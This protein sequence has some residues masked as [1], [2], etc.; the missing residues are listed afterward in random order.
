MD[1][2]TVS[3]VL[4]SGGARGLAHIGAIEVL[5]ENGFQISSVAGC[6]MGALIAGVYAKGNLPQF[7][8]WISNL[9]RVDVFSLMD[10]TISTSGFIKGEKVFQV[11][12]ALLGDCLIEDLPIPFACNAVDI[13]SGQEKVFTEGSLFSAIRA[14][15]A[16]PT[17]IQPAL[18]DNIS[19]IDGGILNPIPVELIKDNQATLRIASDVN[20][21]QQCLVRQ[22]VLEEGS[23]RIAIPAWVN[24]YKAKVSKYL[25]REK[26]AP[27]VKTLSFLDLMNLSMDMMQDRISDYILEQHPVDVHVKISRKQCGTFEFYRAKEIIEIGREITI[28]ALQEKKLI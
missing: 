1:Q 24:E 21:P 10:F 25:P 5:E 13:I 7:K 18:I 12:Q 4:S 16:I 8:E 17:V 11:I 14:S 27:K 28:E 9:D 26:K 3:L 20:G 15:A 2:K 19:Y 6:S 23:S 22:K